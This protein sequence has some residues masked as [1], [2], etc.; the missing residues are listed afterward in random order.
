[1]IKRLAASQGIDAL[2]LIKTEE[3]LAQEM[4]Q[5]QQNQVG[6]SLVD[7]AGQLAKAPMV[8]QAMPQQPTE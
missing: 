7:Q 3:Q 2:N 8:E 4:Q 1:V 5:Q 6:Q